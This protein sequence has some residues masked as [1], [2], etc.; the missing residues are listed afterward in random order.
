M[1]YLKTQLYYMFT[2]YSI[3]HLVLLYSVRCS[4]TFFLLFLQDG[5][6]AL[7]FAA[8]KNHLEIIK[9]LTSHGA[10]I[11]IVTEV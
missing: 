4:C 9:L 8:S 5:W 1:K 3:E 10:D 6:T 2:V 11:T 7:H